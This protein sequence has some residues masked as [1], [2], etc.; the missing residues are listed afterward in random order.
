[1]F[2][3]GLMFPS[4]GLGNLKLTCFP[5]TWPIQRP[6]NLWT[7]F[8]SQVLDISYIR[9]HLIYTM[10]PFSTGFLMRTL[11]RGYRICTS[12]ITS[13]DIQMLSKEERYLVNYY[14]LSVYR[15][16]FNCHGCLDISPI[17]LQS[18]LLTNLILNHLG[19]KESFG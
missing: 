4:M 8:I 16:W 15:L 1:M 2:V 18:A 19:A 6:F 3:R 5:L 13:Y 17:D 14:P 12:K 10:H 9:N 7:V 11:L